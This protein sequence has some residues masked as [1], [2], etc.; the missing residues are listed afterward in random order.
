MLRRDLF[1]Q[2]LNPLA[3]TVD[4][5]FLGGFPKSVEGMNGFDFLLPPRIV[6]DSYDGGFFRSDHRHEHPIPASEKEP[7]VDLKFRPVLKIIRFDNLANGFQGLV[8]ELPDGGSPS[9]DFLIPVSE[10]HGLSLRVNVKK[11]FQ[12]HKTSENHV[13]AYNL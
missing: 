3:E 12:K 8:S 5:Q 7:I 10:R 6:W 1:G 2:L 4:P 13:R 9:E 11:K